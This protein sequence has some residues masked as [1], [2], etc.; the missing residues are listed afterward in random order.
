MKPWLSLV[1]AFGLACVTN[2]TLAALIV[3]YPAPEVAN[4]TRYEQIELL[5]TALEKT[6][7]EMGPYKVQKS[8]FPMTEARYLS[9]LAKGKLINIAW[10]VASEDK[11]RDFIPVRI[12]ISKGL[13]GYRISLINPAIQAKVDSVKTVDDL[14]KLTVGQGIGWGEV[15]L[16]QAVGVKV[17]S[18]NYDNLFKMCEKNR[19]DL[20]PLGVNEIFKEYAV[21]HEDTPKCV[22]EQHMVIY[23]PW[24][25]YFFFNKRDTALAKRVETGLRMMLKD[26]SFDAIFMKYNAENIRRAE[27]NKRRIIRIPNPH[28]PKLTPIN[29]TRL[30]FKP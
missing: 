14:K 10:S 1:T 19:F 11:E 16:Y 9:E 6:A 17:T 4:D 5:T 28:L 23:Y 26:G 18:S 24:P 20:F 12:P 21:R 3:T 8:L 2:I 22:I 7:Q 25:Y 29:D 13:L 15:K 27:L 30:W